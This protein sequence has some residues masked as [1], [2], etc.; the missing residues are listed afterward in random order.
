MIARSWRHG[1]LPLGGGG[2]GLLR[3][4]VLRPSPPTGYGQDAD[5]LDEPLD[6]IAY[7]Y[8]MPG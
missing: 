3:K 2:L 5:G 1:S 4:S 8:P 7:R 6:E